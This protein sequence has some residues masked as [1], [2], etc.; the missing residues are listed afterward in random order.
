MFATRSNQKAATEPKVERPAAVRGSPEGNFLWQSLSLRPEAIRGKLAVSQPGDPFE[1][2]A[3]QTADRIMGIEPSLATAPRFSFLSSGLPLAQR[4]CGPCEEDEQEQLQ[5][6]AQGGSIDSAELA[7]DQALRSPGQPLD[8][9]T[10]SLMESRFRHNFGRV[11]VHTSSDA[12]A[13]AQALQ[14]R[15]YT[16]GSHIVFAAGEYAPAKP[17]GRMLVAH[18]LTHVVQQRQAPIS[19][20]TIEPAGSPAEREAD[21]NAIAVSRGAGVST[22]ATPRGISRDVGWAQRGPLPDPYGMGYNDILKAAGAGATPAIR[23]LMS[24]EKSDMTVN[25]ATFLQ[26]PGS[27][28]LEVLNLQPHAAGTV[29]ESWFPLLRNQ[30]QTQ[31]LTMEDPYGGATTVTAHYFPGQTD[32]RA[33]IIGG[34]HNRTEPQGAAVV[35]RLRVLLT[36]RPTLPFFTTILVPNLFPAARFSPGDPRWI[37]GGMG[38]DTSGT[39]ETTRAVEP[40]RNFPLPGEDLAAAQAR[41]SAGATAP[42]LVFTDPANPSAPPGP[43]R[44]ENIA[45]HAGTSIRMLPET[46]TLISLIEHFHPERIASVHAHSLKRLPGDAPGIFV[47][48]RGVDPTTG[49]VTNAGQAAEDDRLATAMVR[50]GS[51][52]YT[53]AT[54]GV[55]SPDPFVGNRPGTSRS[56]VHYAAGAH[57]QGNSLG[58]WAPTPVTSGPGARPGI[59]TVTIEVPQW[60][61]RSERTELNR[62]EDLDRDLLADIF[63]EDPAT[64]TPAT[65]P[66]TP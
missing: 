14:A 49:T 43:A 33:L 7:P 31:G 16:I 24:L 36:N 13:S 66:V 52:Q 11:R 29:V 57:A 8:H 2:E 47:D 37:R 6:K 20:Q 35:E 39:L 62:I 28:A 53:P 9:T 58:M 40:N 30:L 48:P 25:L 19:S 23:D 12:A 41:G 65:G 45:G 27:R 50:Q 56:T 5:R 26:M 64:A 60:T 42:E 22:S 3:D 4:K 17:A 51:S 46:R 38:N 61:D 10:R 44:D 1:Q 18:E 63:L 59:T 15:A 54:T 34:V 55:R 21:S 32:R